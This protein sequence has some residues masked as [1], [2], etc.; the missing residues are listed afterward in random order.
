MKDVAF[1]DIIFIPAT[2]LFLF[3]G[4]CSY[5]HLVLIERRILSV[6]IYFA[7]L[8]LLSNIV[9]YFF[10]HPTFNFICFIL[11]ELDLLIWASYRKTQVN[12]IIEDA[13]YVD[14][15][16]KRRKDGLKNG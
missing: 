6:F 4:Y 11:I 8:T 14:E 1:H 9:L 10:K 5:R 2:V 12:K 7:I 3:G 16:E 13:K 15:M